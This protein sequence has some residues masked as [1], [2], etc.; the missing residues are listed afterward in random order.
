ML[1]EEFFR[2]RH[3]PEKIKALLAMA[4]FEPTEEKLEELAGKYYAAD[5]RTIF[6]AID[7]EVIIGVIGIDYTDKPYGVIK[8]IAVSPEMRKQGTGKQLIEYATVMLNLTNIE[9]ETDKDALGFYKACGFE[10][11]E[12]SSQWPGVQ[13]FRCSKSIIE[14]NNTENKII[15]V[16]RG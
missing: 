3:N 16:P 9:A 10:A 14:S 12:I 7:N 13:R 6:I 8:H 11:R 4:V 5:G 15:P 2:N 1:I